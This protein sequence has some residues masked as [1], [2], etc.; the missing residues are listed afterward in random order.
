MNTDTT[1][2]NRMIAEFMGWES[3]KFE[4][5][6]NK[7]H[8]IE[9]GKLWG[10]PLDQFNYNDSW[11]ALIPVIKKIAI[12]LSETKSILMAM[13][14][15]EPIVDAVQKLD[16]EKVWPAVVDYISWHNKNLKP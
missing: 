14:K 7:M 16:I 12:S 9:D 15:Y 3:G 13:N 11:D 4:N 10:I 2:G 5:L 1:E 6:P 8:K